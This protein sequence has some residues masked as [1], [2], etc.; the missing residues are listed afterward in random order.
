MTC[1]GT[2][3]FTKLTQLGTGMYSQSKTLCTDCKGR[4]IMVDRTDICSQCLGQRSTTSEKT[5]EVPIEK[6]IP[7]QHEVT[8][9]GEGDEQPGCIA[10]DII[11]VVDL[12]KHE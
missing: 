9:I 1:R 8:L 12:A 7:N 2:G 6:G 4:G 11:V 10:G 3:T 5:L